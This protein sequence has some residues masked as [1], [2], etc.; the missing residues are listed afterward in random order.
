MLLVGSVNGDTVTSTS[1]KLHLLFGCLFGLLKERKDRKERKD[2]R[3]LVFLMPSRLTNK[4]H[5][6]LLKTTERQFCFAKDS[7]TYKRVEKTV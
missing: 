2:E 7:V 3:H 4:S 1:G 6:L 5:I